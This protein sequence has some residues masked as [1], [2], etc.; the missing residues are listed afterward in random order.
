[1][2][3][4]EGEDTDAIAE[5]GR[6]IGEN[7]KGKESTNP[8]AQVMLAERNPKATLNSKIPL[9]ITGSSCLAWWMKGM[10]ASR[11]SIEANLDTSDP[12]PQKKVPQ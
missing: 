10:K 2:I 6:I 8:P 5:D 4:A 3:A 9:K 11:Q 1:V 12:S 7:I